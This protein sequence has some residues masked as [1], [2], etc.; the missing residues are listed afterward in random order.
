MKHSQLKKYNEIC[1][2]VPVLII[3][4]PDN[5][6]KGLFKGYK[7]TLILIKDTH[8]LVRLDVND[9]R[10]VK[11]KH[12]QIKYLKKNSQENDGNENVS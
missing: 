5:N 2:N 9:N 11:L 3:G 7:G 1:P 8:I 6:N 10:I 4:D 12:N